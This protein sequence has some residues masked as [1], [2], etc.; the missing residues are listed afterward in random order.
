MKLGRSYSRDQSG[1]I[2]YLLHEYKAEYDSWLKLIVGGTLALTLILGIVLLTV[3]LP[4]AWVMFGVTLFDALLFS[5]V[6][7]RRYQIFQDRLKIV[8]G[9]PFA[10]SIPFATIREVRP[11][12]GSK[13][14]VY[15]GIHW[16][17]SS[18]SVVEIVRSQGLSVFISPANRNEFLQEL[19][20]ALKAVSNSK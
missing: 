18:R 16:A 5:S 9:S 8:L 12:S 2:A 11:A 15:W 10:F 1:N 14:L 19:T 13:A 17:T 6:L 20:Q 3:D 4:A 7:P